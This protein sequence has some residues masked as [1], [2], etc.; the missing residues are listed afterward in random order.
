V[1]DDTGVVKVVEVRQPSG[2]I[3]VTTIGHVGKEISGT[4]IYESTREAVSHKYAGDATHT[5]EIDTETDRQ[6]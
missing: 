6:L 4:T 3:S 1:Q 2:G 5:S